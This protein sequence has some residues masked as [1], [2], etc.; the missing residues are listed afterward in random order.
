MKKVGTEKKKRFNAQITN[1]ELISRIFFPKNLEV[2]K[3]KAG[4]LTEK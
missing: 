3:I 4:N 2:S 1:K